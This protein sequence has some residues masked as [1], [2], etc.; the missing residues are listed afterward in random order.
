MKTCLR[1]LLDVIGEAMTEGRLGADA[2]PWKRRRSPQ[3]MNVLQA[4]DRRRDPFLAGFQLQ[5]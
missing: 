5:R 3:V 1:K 2:E 4:V